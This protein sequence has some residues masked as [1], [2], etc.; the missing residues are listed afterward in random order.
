M[1]ED[2][3]YGVERR[4]GAGHSIESPMAGGGRT[5][6]SYDRKWDYIVCTLCTGC[7]KPLGR[8]EN[9]NRLAFCRN[10]R[11]LLFPETVSPEH[12]IDRGFPYRRARSW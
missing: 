5:F 1:Y 3:Y 6:R 12:S 10:C 2:G 11:A 8:Y 7:G 4:H 9:L